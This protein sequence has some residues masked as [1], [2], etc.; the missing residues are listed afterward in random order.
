M[1]LFGQYAFRPFTQPDPNF[2]EPSPFRAHH[3]RAGRAHLYNLAGALLGW[4][5]IVGRQFLGNGVR[6]RTIYQL[7]KSFFRDS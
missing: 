6:C 4:W 1:A 3:V 7:V 2:K 5:A